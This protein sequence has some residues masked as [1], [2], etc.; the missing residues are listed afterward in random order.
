MR[1]AGRSRGVAWVPGVLWPLLLKNYD[2]LYVRS[3]HYTPI[4]MG[5]R[6]SH[7]VVLHV[8]ESQAEHTRL[9]LTP[10]L[11]SHLA[12][13]LA[14]HLAPAARASRATEL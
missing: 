2:Q 5:M 12:S 4:P 1:V 14:F 11:T 8:R 10:C 7:Y 13:H 6:Q 9:W 3:S